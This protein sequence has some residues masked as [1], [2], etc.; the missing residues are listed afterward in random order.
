MS[1]DTDK[2]THFLNVDLDV[3]SRS[4]LEPLVGA[5]GKRVHVLYLGRPRQTYE[6]HLEIAIAPRYPE[7][8][9]R[10]I[11]KFAALINSLPKPARKLWDTAKRRDFNIGLQAAMQPHALEFALAPETVRA[12]A[13]LNARIVITIY[14]PMIEPE[15][16]S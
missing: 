13:S 3:Y 6:A 11:K 7:S 14:A 15:T 8:P 2:S 10:T 5:L 4:N 16:E 1:P 12:A 9:D